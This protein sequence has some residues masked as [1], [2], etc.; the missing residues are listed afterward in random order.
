L[1][2]A[3][4]PVVCNLPLVLCAFGLKSGYYIISVAVSCIRLIKTCNLIDLDC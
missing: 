4:V 2:I 1:V 3:V